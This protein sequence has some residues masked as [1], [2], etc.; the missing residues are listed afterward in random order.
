[1][2][3]PLPPAV[4]RAIRS[5]LTRAKRVPTSE[6]IAW[7]R[8]RPI[9][10]RTVLYESFAGNGA[11]CNPEAIFRALLADPEFADLTH[12]WAI[13]D[14]DAAAALRAEFAGDRRVE[15]VSRGS[16]AYWRAVSTAG[17]LINNA[18]FPTAFSKRVGQVYLNTWHGTPLKLMGF[19]MP[20]GARESAN[21]LRNLL[22]A[23]YLLAANPFMAETMYEDAYQLRNV[24]RGAIIEEGYPRIDRQRMPEAERVARIADLG[25]R[26]GVDLAGRRIVLFAPTWRG[27]SF[28]AP[29]ADLA[30]LADQAAGLQRQLGDDAV[31]LLK[32]HQVVHRAASGIQALRRLLVPNTTPTNVLLGLAD[33]LVTDYSS[34]FFDYLATDRPIGFLVPDGDAYGAERGTYMPLDELPGPV[35]TDPE[36]LGRD[37]AA[38]LAPGAPAHPRYADWARRFVPHEDGG[39]TSRVIDVVFRGRTAER[40]V[41][42]VRR[43]ERPRLLFY[44]GGMRLNGITTAAVNLLNSLDTEKYDVTALMAFP[45]GATTTHNQSRL[46]PGIRQVFRVGGMNGLKARQIMRRVADVSTDPLRAHRRLGHRTL[47]RDEWTR[48][49]GS[50]KFDWVADFSGYSPFWAHLML[51]SPRAVRAIWLHNE[52]AA[53]RDRTV[54]GKQPF[55][56]SLGRVFAMYRAYDQ[57]VSVSPALTDLNRAE[58]AEYAPGDRFVTLR[59][60][61]DIVSATALDER[62]EDGEEPEEDAALGE[63]L[64]AALAVPGIRRFVTVGRLST[65]KNH[66]R[67]IRAFA[68]LSATEPDTQLLI[69]GGGPLRRDLEQQVRDAGLTGRVILTGPLRDPASVMRRCDCFVLSSDYEGQ[70]MVLIEAAQLGLP[71][72]STAFGSARGALPGDDMHIV[73]RED[74]ALAAGMADFLAGR[75]APASLDVAAYTAEVLAQFDALIP[76]TPGAS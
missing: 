21:T 48:I 11:L 3:S 33:A 74:T 50:A 35:H 13:S 18:T 32:T 7:S 28:Q 19:D 44:L 70:P 60:L 69:V 40:R 46:D 4:T 64:D 72:V 53:D 10:H 56:R 58:L 49:F 15:I 36:A 22:N 12:I 34:I 6:L 59:N 8:S 61:P 39:A 57:L 75:V 9:R 68:L 47:W 1:M 71:I 62:D 52:M 30:H 63:T 26:L 55:R 5:A 37:L 27:S 42:P 29:D 41:R 45:R 25:S 14:A 54:N 51:H 65:E 67:L 16:G 20:G 24:Y 31:V 38:L 43:D 66:A 23:D 2:R 76:R 73:D 17:Y